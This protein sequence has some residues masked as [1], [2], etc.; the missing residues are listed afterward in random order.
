M[1][2]HQE[3]LPDSGRGI[4]YYHIFTIHSTGDIVFSIRED[5]SHGFRRFS[6]VFQMIIIMKSNDARCVLL[7]I[8]SVNS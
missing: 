7:L 5:V 6:Q 2:D 8:A 4:M 1:I 3:P